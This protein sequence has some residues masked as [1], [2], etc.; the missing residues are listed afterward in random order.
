MGN[1]PTTTTT[2]QTQTK[3]PWEPTAQ[4][5]TNL[6]ATVGNIGGNVGNFTP[7][8]SDTTM[9]G[10]ASLE[11][12][13]SNG[14]GAYDALS[15]VVPGSTAGF[16]TGLGQLQNVASGGMINRNQYLDPV[17][18]E[19]ARRTAD[20][21]NGQFS[22]AGRYGSGAHTGTLTR[23]IG[24]L[25]NKALLDNYNTERTAQD[26][27]ARTLYGG[28]FQGAGMGGALDQA[29]INPALLQIQ[30]G[31]MRDQIANAQ[32]TAPMNAA[33]WQAKMLMPMAGIGGTSSGT[34]T[35]QQK[36][37]T[38]W[39]TTGMGIGMAGLGALSGNPMALANLG[40]NLG[41]LAGGGGSSGG[42]MVN[43]F[44]NN[45]PAGTYYY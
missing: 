44:I 29:E 40:S 19:S 31:Q 1:K 33:E 18:T 25:T 14:S 22:A 8:T 42:G 41:S 23:E 43:G 30:A 12:A 36:T 5:L 24:N 13:A 37:P 2:T 21:V 28:G 4:P 10:I 39:L 27:A 9:S 38:N 11:R 6:A 17:L 32:R 45:D 16:T 3:N 35:Q 15:T 7:T 20:A 26:N 34:G